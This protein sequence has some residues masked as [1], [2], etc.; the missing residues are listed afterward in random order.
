[1]HDLMPL[2]VR[3]DGLL[4]VYKARAASCESAVERHE[5]EMQIW[6]LTKL[7]RVRKAMLALMA[8]A[9][10]ETMV[11]AQWVLDIALRG[12]GA[13]APES[14]ERPPELD[15]RSTVQLSVGRRPT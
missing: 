9:S 11:E 10:G 6:T 13:D 14:G 2:H 8:G 7:I 5:L 1:M 4:V 3:L 12:L 15:T